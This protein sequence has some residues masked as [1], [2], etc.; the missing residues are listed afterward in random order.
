M[1]IPSFSRL[2]WVDVLCNMGGLLGWPLARSEWEWTDLLPHVYKWHV[3]GI[4]TDFHVTVWNIW[5]S[6]VINARGHQVRCNFWWMLWMLCILRK[7]VEVTTTKC[8]FRFL[9]IAI[10]VL[11]RRKPSFFSFMSWRRKMKGIMTNVLEDVKDVWRECDRKE[12]TVIKVKSLKSS[13]SEKQRMRKVDRKPSRYEDRR[14]W[15]RE[16]GGRGRTAGV[17]GRKERERIIA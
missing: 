11:S 15:G 2:F 4:K 5:R 3:R 10:C 13:R 7:P 8:H 9:S 16:E 6:K 12:T 17:A 14:N 1:C